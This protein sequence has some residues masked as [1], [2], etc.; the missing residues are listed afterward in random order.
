MI[1]LVA[2]TLIIAVEFVVIVLLFELV[3]D[4]GGWNYRQVVFLYGMAAAP[5][6]VTTLTIASV[7]SLAEHVRAGT[8]D[9][10]L[11]RP[12]PAMVQLVGNEFQLR[13]VGKMLT[14]FA[15][16]IWAIPR[17]GIDWNLGTA[18]V[19]AMAFVCGTLIYSALWIATASLSFWVVASREATNAATYGGEFAN[20]YPLHLYRGWIRAVLGWALPLAFVAYV[21][22]IHLFGAEAEAATNPLGLPSWLVYTTPAVTAAALAVSLGLWSLGIRHYQSTGS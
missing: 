9:R 15:V 7:E 13:R 10:L 16:L 14:P 11:L 19:F 22:A 21:P 4:L 2:Q 17:A 18:V 1:Y 12:V 8:F 6:S 3:P 20:E 5:F